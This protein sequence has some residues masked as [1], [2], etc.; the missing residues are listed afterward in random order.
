MPKT[1]DYL[2]KLFE[3]RDNLKA[4]LCN[5]KVAIGQANQYNTLIP[6]M[7]LIETG[8]GYSHASII[9]NRVQTLTFSGFNFVPNSFAIS[10]EY[11]L[12]HSYSVAGNAYNVVG[13]LSLDG[14]QLGNQS[15]TVEVMLNDILSTITVTTVMSNTN[16]ISTLT[17]TLPSGFYF[18][19]ECKWAV[20]G[21]TEW[22]EDSEEED[23]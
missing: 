23:E 14:L 6:L 7:G 17:V 18:L 19:G 21:S 12:E 16:G 4:T 3:S 5:F 11:A 10:S 15:H 9:A 1:G 8:T 2:L 20:L 13:A 22:D